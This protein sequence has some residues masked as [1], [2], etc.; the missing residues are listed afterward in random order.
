MSEIGGHRTPGSVDIV[1]EASKDP[2]VSMRHES[3]MILWRKAA[4]GLD[5]EGQIAARLRQAT[6]DPDPDV[7]AVAR[8]ALD[9]LRR[10]ESAAP[11]D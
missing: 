8:D 11:G 4:D 1:L 7:A 5:E 2:D 3:V 10:L 6:L 9:D